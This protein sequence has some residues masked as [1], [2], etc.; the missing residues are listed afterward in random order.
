MVIIGILG[1]IASGKTFVAQ[2]FGRLGA[3]VIDADRVAHEV[4]NDTD[5]QR[6]IRLRWGDAVF[7]SEGNVDRAAVSKIVFETTAA[8]AQE[9]AHLEQLTH[10]H[11][12][13]RIQ[14][15]TAELAAARET[16]AV[17]L[18]AAVLLKAGWREFC[19]KI[20]FVEAPENQRL[21][22]ARRRGWSETDF[23]AREAA[24]ESLDE[25]RK[26]ADW[27]IDN[28]ISAEHTFAQVQRIW[29]SLN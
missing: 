12:R 24:Q 11:I 8:G 18:D 20:V 22:R 6:A 9:L 4:L 1:G 26:Y 29:H 7:D 14:Q 25:K 5:V 28:G 17:A 19:D 21:M 15:R 27:V 10:P 3:S 23:S 13:D 16:K 2:Q